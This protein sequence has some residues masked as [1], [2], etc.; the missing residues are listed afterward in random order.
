MLEVTDCPLPSCK[1]E[2]RS[3][4]TDDDNN[5]VRSV[6]FLEEASGSG[7]ASFNDLQPNTLYSFTLTCVGTNETI[8]RDIRSTNGR[9]SAPQNI[10]VKLNSKR[11]TLFWS[12]PLK[13][14]GPI[15]NYKL[16]MD[17]QVLTYNISNRQFSYTMTEDY[18]YGRKHVFYLQACNLDYQNMPLCSDRKDGNTTF[19]MPM[20]TT[21]IQETNTQENA[22]CVKL[23]IEISICNNGKSVRTDV[24]ECPPPSCQCEVKSNAT[25]NDKIHPVVFFEETPNISY[26]LFH[27]LQPNT[28]YSFTLTCA[29]TNETITRYIR[30]D[31]GIPSSP[32]NITVKLNSQRLTLFWSSPIQPA[33]PIYNYKLTIDAKL[34]I[35]NIPNNQFS[36]TITED[37]IY[38]ER[39]LFYLQACNINRQ[40]Q[41]ECS[42][43]NDG[44]AT[45]FMPMTT[46]STQETS[47]QEN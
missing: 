28:L 40:N 45:F 6:K 9:P 8:T 26:V 16:A 12:S 43:P 37:F 3:N 25:S 32:K 41:S 14:A 19:F 4:A 35:N 21:S 27:N 18:V 44:N 30:T 42:N 39:Y 36:Y 20:A 31:Y 33:G 46:I 24:I 17:Q 34:T 29:G 5:D 11:L 38:G 15:H 47:T 13:P 7:Y 10:T 23:S 2:V 1:C 22:S